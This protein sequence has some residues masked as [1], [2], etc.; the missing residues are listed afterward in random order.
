VRADLLRRLGRPDQAT[1]AYG[2]AL[3]LTGNAAERRFLAESLAHVAEPL[4]H[5]ASHESPLY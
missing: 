5:S 3:D 1:V 4:D 2:K